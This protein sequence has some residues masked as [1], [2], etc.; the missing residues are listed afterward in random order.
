MEDIRNVGYVN[1]RLAMLLIIFRQPGANIIET[2]DRVLAALPQ[3][4]AEV[5]AAL[6]MNVILDRTTTI[7]G[8]VKD[9]EIALGISISLVIMVVFLLSLIH[10]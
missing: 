6:H 4:Q 3:L 7:R 9:V 5:P 2:V 1:G 10:I 8:S